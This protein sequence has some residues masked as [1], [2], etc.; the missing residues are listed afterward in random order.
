MGAGLESMFCRPPDR[1]HVGAGPGPSSPPS[2]GRDT[3]SCAVLEAA[4]NAVELVAGR[5]H[6]NR[7]RCCWMSHGIDYVRVASG[8]ADLRG[9]GLDHEI[10]TIALPKCP[11]HLH[12]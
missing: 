4:D 12:D 6:R 10:E 2:R 9:L 1:K 3:D 5:D 11:N 7:S 8:E